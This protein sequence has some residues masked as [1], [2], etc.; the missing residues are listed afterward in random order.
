VKKIARVRIVHQLN[1]NAGVERQIPVQLE[2][3]A[4]TANAWKIPNVIETE[5]VPGK[6]S[7]DKGVVILQRM[8]GHKRMRRH[9][10]PIPLIE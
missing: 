4:K 7:A 2:R 5:T 10:T 8:M 1:P 3:S 6:T 9:P